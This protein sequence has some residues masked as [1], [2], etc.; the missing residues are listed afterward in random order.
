MLLRH[1]KSPVIINIEKVMIKAIMNKIVM[2]HRRLTAFLLS[3]AVLYFC[4]LLYSLE[5]DGEPVWMYDYRE[6]FFDVRYLNSGKAVIVGSRGRVL[7]KHGTYGNLWSPRESETGESLTCL[8]FVDERNG[9]AAGHGGVVIHTGDSGETWV[10][11]RE[12]SPEHQPL[13]DISFPSLNTGYACGAYDTIIKTCDG[14]K[15]WEKLTTG[16]DNIYNGLDFIDEKTGFLVGE[17]GTILK[18]VNGGRSWRRLDI[19]NYKGTIMGITALSSRK[20]LACGIKG[21]LIISNDG[22]ET[23][24]NIKSGV[25]EP[26]FRA[27]YSGNEVLI[28]GRM[29]VMLHS[30]DGGNTFKAECEKEFTTFSGVSPCPGG[31]FIC[32]GEMGRIYIRGDSTDE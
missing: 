12:P 3:G 20:I 6:M 22:G 31:G 5:A 4:G 27:A 13:L 18:T 32:V 15:S 24:S 19:G 14:G 1:L 17:F 7:V 23:W 2:K 16:S 26:L 30:S 9:W 8:S 11:Q 28:V 21:K 25:K 10:V 29:G